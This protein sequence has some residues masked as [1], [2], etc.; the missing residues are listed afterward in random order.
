MKLTYINFTS[1]KLVTIRLN[2]ALIIGRE[3]CLVT[4][5]SVELTEIGS[6]DD[7]VKLTPNIISNVKSTAYKICH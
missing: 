7:S 5:N 1:S 6:V 2:L 4:R 3:H